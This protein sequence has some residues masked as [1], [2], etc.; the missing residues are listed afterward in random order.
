MIF[1]TFALHNLLFLLSV[2]ASVP[3][4]NVLWPF[5]TQIEIASVTSLGAMFHSLIASLMHVFAESVLEKA[6]SIDLPLVSDL[7]TAV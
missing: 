5:A 7:V 3:I 1:E 2:Y 6:V 4:F